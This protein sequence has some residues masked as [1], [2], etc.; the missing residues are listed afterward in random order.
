MMRN[1][2][3]MSLSE[4]YEKASTCGALSA[5]AAAGTKLLIAQRPLKRHLV[6]GA[7]RFGERPDESRRPEGGIPSRNAAAVP[8]VTPAS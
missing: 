3:Q 6:R 4:R 5:T 8:E 1:L 7:A 2:S